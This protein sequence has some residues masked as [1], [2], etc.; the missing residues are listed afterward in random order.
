MRMNI[1]AKLSIATLLLAAAGSISACNTI[2][3]VGEDVSALGK[4]V[5][6]GA[7][8]VQKSM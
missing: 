6:K 2:G 4:G 7:D 1:I 8:N 3:G 5:T